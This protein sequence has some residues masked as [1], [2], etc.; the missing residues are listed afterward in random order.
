MKV[1]FKLKVCVA[2]MVF[3]VVSPFLF[4]DKREALRVVIATTPARMVPGLV[5][6]LKALDDM[7]ESFK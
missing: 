4:H 3:C 1:T 7:T 6:T 5:Q 2:L